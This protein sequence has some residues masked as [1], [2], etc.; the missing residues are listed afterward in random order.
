MTDAKGWR[1]ATEVEVAPPL[2]AG[3]Q[4]DPSLRPSSAIDFRTLFEL[5]GDYVAR[6]LRRLG[7][8]PSEIEDTVHD[9]FVAVHDRLH[10]YDPQRPVRPW[11][12]AFAFRI[13][14]AEKRR[15]YHRAELSTEVPD[16]AD[17]SRSA[18]ELVEENEN[19]AVLLAAL[20]ALLPDQCAVVTLHELDGVPVPEIAAA[21]DIP[22]NTAYSRLRLGREALTRAVR[23]LIAT[24][25]E[26]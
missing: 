4:K 24:R 7:V 13:A 17:G 19:R 15:P 9:V 22:L 6:S 20:A 23:R 1:Q 16:V 26:R 25:G 21:L 12:F 18:D 8:R 11:L 10:E 3:Q 5:E 2:P 14:S